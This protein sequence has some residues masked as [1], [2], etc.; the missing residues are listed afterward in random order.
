MKAAAFITRKPAA[1]VVA[2]LALTELSLRVAKEIK[3]YRY[4]TALQS[5][6]YEYAFADANRKRRKR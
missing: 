1:L 4:H 3:T 2:G 6:D 5:R